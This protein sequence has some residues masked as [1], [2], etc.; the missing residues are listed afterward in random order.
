MRLAEACRELGINPKITIII[1][2]KRHHN[3]YVL[4]FVHF[5]IQIELFSDC[6]LAV[7]VLRIGVRI[8]PLEVSSIVGSYIPLTLI[9]FSKVMLV[10]LAPVALLITQYVFH[11]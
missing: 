6:S 1:V 3:Q 11:L 4:L 10:F 8:V 2:G 7:L 5:V 9:S